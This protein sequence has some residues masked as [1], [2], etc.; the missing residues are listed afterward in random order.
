MRREAA[1]ANSFA[2]I[3]R[4][5]RETFLLRFLYDLDGKM[6]ITNV[7]IVSM[8][9]LGLLAA[10]VAGAGSLFTR[11]PEGT[12]RDFT[13]QCLAGDWNAAE[14]FLPPDDDV[15]LVEFQRW[16]GFYFTSILDKHR[17]AGDSVQVD[18]VREGEAFVVTMTSRVIGKRTIREQWREQDGVWQFDPVATLAAMNGG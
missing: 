9:A 1:A 15:A 16:R 4:C 12:V 17:P 10:V 2:T 13:Y 18:V 7:V 14:E 11:T 5:P 8:L 6:R 3:S